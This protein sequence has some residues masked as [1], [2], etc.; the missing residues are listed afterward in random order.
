MRQD[1]VAVLL[2]IAVAGEHDVLDHRGLDLD[3]VCGLAF[4]VAVTNPTLA[5]N[6][7]TQSRYVNK[8]RTFQPD[9]VVEATAVCDRQCAGC[10]A[11][12]VISREAPIEMLARRPDLFLAPA[13]LQAA[14][15]SHLQQRSTPIRIVGIRGGEPT[16]HP[17]LTDIL[18][19]LR[20]NT[21]AAIY[22]ETHGRW[23]LSDTPNTELLTALA[24]H[25]SIVKLSFDR[26]HGL[27]AD[28]LRDLTRRLSQSGVAW[29]VAITEQDEAAFSNTR[30]TCSWIDD[31][32]LFY[33]PKV[34]SAAALLR[35]EC[36]VI[37]VSGRL[38][39]GLSV[40][41]EFR[42]AAPEHPGVASGA[43]A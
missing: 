43:L 21:D 27:A 4:S 3:L 13:T 12:N 30:A 15:Q 19:A 20:S 23:L 36:S 38:S 14:L 10:Y 1:S 41:S 29:C 32:R 37:S 8:A 7:G 42:S 5:T 6:R 22:L 24:A 40:R 2:G 31:N 34:Y 18:S 25:H 33:Q 16:R 9:L 28:E 11:P 17:H 39:G 26:M 35:A